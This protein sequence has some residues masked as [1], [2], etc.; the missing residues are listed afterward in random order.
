VN[1]YKGYLAYF[2]GQGQRANEYQHRA[3]D[4]LPESNLYRSEAELHY[5]LSL[6]MTGKKES[7][8]QQLKDWLVPGRNLTG[9]HHTRLWGGLSFIHLLEGELKEITYPAEK[10]QTIA[11]QINDTYTEGYAL[12]IQSCAHLAQNNQEETAQKLAWIADNRYLLQTR[13]V[14][15]SYC[16]LALLYQLQ[17]QPDKVKETIRQ[18]LEFVREKNDTANILIASSCQAHLSLMNG[19]IPAAVRWLRTANL[20][21]DTGI[22]LWW[23]E[24]PRITACRVQIAEG[25]HDS[26]QKAIDQLEVYQKENQ[27]VHNTYQEIVMLPLLA[28]AYHKQE[29]D[30]KALA[31]LEEALRLG[32]PGGWIWPFTELGS[33]IADMLRRLKLQEVAKE[34][35]RYIDRILAAF[36]APASAQLSSDQLDLVE[37]LTERERQVLRLLATILSPDEIANELVVSVNTVRM[38]TKNIYSKLEVHSRMEAV[39]RARDL[40]LI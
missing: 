12:Y 36:P 20:D 40:R 11:S 27:A 26:L 28:L 2:Q 6:H 38:H 1:Y 23:I 30:D 16:G 3:I 25:S 17:N 7:A 34:M 37:P 32:Y 19:D 4:L 29:Q 24:L 22:M 39:E 35:E 10:L 5:A 21:T 13:T 8:I 9:T 33:Q 18:M 14:L 31:N 15:D